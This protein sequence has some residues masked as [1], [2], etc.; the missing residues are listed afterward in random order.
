ML[1]VDCDTYIGRVPSG[2]LDSPPEILA[3]VERANGVSFAMCYSLKSRTYDAR[4]GND[5]TL[6]AARRHRELLPVASVDP[7]E[8]CRVEAE[9]ARAAE[10]GFVAVRVFPELQGWQVDSLLFTRVVSACAQHGVPLMIAAGAPGV[11]SSVVQAAKHTDAPIIL[12]GANYNTLAEALSAAAARNNTY[13]S[14]QYLITPQAVEIAVDSVGIERLILGTSCPDLTARSAINVVMMSTLSDTDKAAVLG[15]NAARLVEHQLPKLGKVLSASSADAYA[16]RRINGPMIDVHGHIGPWPFPMGSCGVADL[17]RMMRNCGIEKAVISHTKA[18]VSDFVE[19]NADLARDLES[20]EMLLGYVTVNPSHFEQ[21][22]REMDTYLAN[23]KFVG[24]KLHPSYAGVSIDHQSTRA[25]A[26][27]VARRNVP[28]LIHTMGAGEPSKILKL[29]QEFPG[30]PIIMGHGGAGAWPE[31]ID[32]LRHATNVYTEFCT[33]QCHRS[34][35]RTTIDA[36]GADRILFGT[37]LGLF[38]P[39]YGMGPYEE[40]ALSPDEETAIMRTNAK[41][42][43]GLDR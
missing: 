15:G 3:E 28:F 29:A 33:S 18:I 1:I 40:A 7:R 39:A 8:H 25:L 14:T 16:A 9:V 32:V 27:E 43:F 2:Q 24:V 6:E 34:K 12:L 4:E 35:V 17:E 13:V 10:L 38:D 26:S 21:S 19:G 41:R 5:D 20:T 11:A 37:D 31:A 23:P 30:M 42:L 22:V 36:V